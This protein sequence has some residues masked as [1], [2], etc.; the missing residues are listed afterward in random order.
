MNDKEIED[1]QRFAHDLHT[2]EQSPSGKGQWRCVACGVTRQA[3][4][5]VQY[6]LCPVAVGCEF[7]KLTGPERG[8]QIPEYCEVFR[9]WMRCIREGPSAGEHRDLIEAL[10]LVELAI[11][12][13][14]LLWRLLCGEETLR[15]VPC[16]V[17]KGVWSGIGSP[18]CGC[19]NTGWLPAE[20]TDEQ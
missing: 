14:S 8:M 15:T 12:K 20:K 7:A 10:S 4:N 17:H 13:S 9:T 19:H 11:A 3:V 1:L 2:C 6:D 18:P 16:P 5:K